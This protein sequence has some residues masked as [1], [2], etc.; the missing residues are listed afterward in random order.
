MKKYIIIL[1]L[2]FGISQLFAQSDAPGLYGK[3]L[4]IELGTSTAPSFLQPT[5]NYN[6]EIGNESG[7]SQLYRFSFNHQLSAHYALNR[8][9]TVGISI[10]YGRTGFYSPSPIVNANITSTNV[11]FFVRRYFLRSGSIAPI[12]NYIQF[13]ASAMF[14]RRSFR[15]SALSFD[16]PEVIAS[17]VH[18]SPAVNFEYGRETFI[19]DKFLYSFAFQTGLALPYGMDAASKY[20]IMNQS[21]SDTMFTRLLS[22]Y[23]V[24]FKFA[25][26]LAIK[27]KK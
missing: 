4:F 11:N 14:N 3:K 24:R 27:T 20:K 12:G 18:V 6:S 26:G 23:S 5:Y 1:S 7:F 2:T 13:G 22:Y 25:V 10:G 21:I 16:N 19:N 9:R 8:L 15:Q 17:R